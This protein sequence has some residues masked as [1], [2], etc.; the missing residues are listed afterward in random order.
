MKVIKPLS[1]SVAN[2]PLPQAGGK[3]CLLVTICAGYRQNNESVALISEPNFWKELSTVLPKQTAPDLCFDKPFSEWLAFGRVYP[4]G[5][6]QVSG[7]ASIEIFRNAQLLSSKKLHFCGKRKWLKRLG[8]GWPTDPEKLS[9]PILLDWST[10]FGGKNHPV[11]PHGLGMYE[12]SWE[13]QELPQV[14]IFN[15]LISSPKDSPDPAGFGPLPLDGSARFKPSGTYDEKWQKK[16]YPALASDTP[17]EVMMMTSQDQ[18]VKVEF[19]AGDKI[20]CKGMVE[21][22]KELVWDIPKWQPRCFIRRSKYSHELVPL[23]MRL[24]TLCILPHDGVLGLMWR[25]MVEISELDAL[26]VDLLFAA[27]EDQ[28]APKPITHYEEQIS[29]RSFVQKDAALAMIDDGPL[30][31]MGQIGSLMSELSQESK[32]RIQRMQKQAEKLKAQAQQKKEAVLAK[33]SQ[34]QTN[35]QLNVQEKQTNEIELLTSEM[36]DIFLSSQ[37]NSAR[38]VEI[39]KRMQ[40]LA[41]EERKKAFKDLQEVLKKQNIDI[42]DA[43]KNNQKK[44]SGPPSRNLKKSLDLFGGVFKKGL[45]HQEKYEIAEKKI[46]ES[47]VKQNDIYRKTAH[48]MPTASS[49]IEPKL[50]GQQIIQYFETIESKNNSLYGVDWLGAD[51]VAVDLR[52]KKLDGVFLDGANLRNAMLQGISMQDATLSNADLSQANLT[53]ANLENCNFGNANLSG[54]DF[55]GANLKNAIFDKANLSQANFSNAQMNSSSFIASTVLGANFSGAILDKS[56]F[57]GVKLEKEPDASLL[58]LGFEAQQNLYVPMIFTGVSFAKAQLNQAIFLACEGEAINFTGVNIEKTSFVECKFDCSNFSHA[59]L[60]S[61]NFVMHS[62]LKKSNFSN[63]V[64]ESCFLRDM[65]IEFS[66][67]SEANLKKTNFSLSNLTNMNAKRSNVSQARFDRAKLIGSNFEDAQM[68]SA[69]LQ[70]ALLSESNFTRADLTLADF[71]KADINLTT[72]FSDAKFD[73]TKIKQN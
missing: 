38:L 54:V 17:A 25:G 23:M 71:T 19:Q 47:L 21:G 27:L 64:V 63:A 65:D 16:D 50:L 10:S 20:I 55:T 34:S 4:S 66:D 49:L 32:K 5:K 59:H 15:Q 52:E 51:L 68:N 24:D 42:E 33:F 58:E 67:F 12:D 62:S 44:G 35:Q 37:P 39:T 56:K 48:L 69:F 70:G 30:L 2:R 61:V 31:P 13:G 60:T 11:N 9:E 46:L 1:L 6:E 43:L 26:D 18:W 73:Y 14:E 40:E 22:G 7:L 41:L 8:V 29:K 3:I 28:D 57:M 36:T 72:I 53:G 45:I